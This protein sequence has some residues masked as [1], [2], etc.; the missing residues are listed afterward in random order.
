MKDVVVPRIG[1]EMSIDEP[2][3]ASLYKLLLY[4]SGC[5]FKPHRDAEREAGMFATLVVQLPSKYS[6]G[7]LIVTHENKIKKI[8]L[9]SAV[10]PENEFATTFSAFYCDCKHEVLPVTDGV[11]VCLIYNLIITSAAVNTIPSAP[12]SADKE[13]MMGKIL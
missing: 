11:R 2:I 1:K 5:F 9:S 13:I 7:E 3:S 12:L 8:D 4:K 6:G 10:N